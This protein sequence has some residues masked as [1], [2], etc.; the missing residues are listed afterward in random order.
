MGM[1]RMNK[2]LR[3]RRRIFH[4]DSIPTAKV[5]SEKKT[6]INTVRKRTANAGHASMT[7]LFRVSCAERST[8]KTLMTT[9]S[10]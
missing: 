5:I 3:K 4:T 9:D 7:I 8:G 6:E 1:S 2:N 10:F